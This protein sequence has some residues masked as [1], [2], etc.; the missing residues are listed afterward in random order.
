MLERGRFK[1]RGVYFAHPFDN[2]YADAVGGVSVIGA[3]SDWANKNEGVLALAAVIFPLLMILVSFVLSFFQNNHLRE[4]LLDLRSRD[5]LITRYSLPGQD[6]YFNGL[7]RVLRLAEWIY[8]PKA[9]SWR[10]YGSCL[11]IAVIYPLLAV[12]LGWVLF[13]I[14]NPAGIEM[15]FD[16]ENGRERALRFAVFTLGMAVATFVFR[17]IDN[18]SDYLNAQ[19]PKGLDFSKVWPG[20]L[21][22]AA[23]GLGPP[24]IFG[25]AVAFAFAFAAAVAGAFAFAG[26]GAFAF[27]VAFAGTFAVAFAFAS[28]SA[29]AVAFAGA[30]AFG[31]AEAALILLLYVFLPILNAAADMISLWIT[32]GFL[33]N[34]LTHRPH[35]GWVLAQ[36]LVDL[37]LAA[38]C[39]AALIAL[40]IGGLTIWAEISPASV[41][42]DWRAYWADVHADPRAGVAL[43]IMALT[44]LV[45]TIIHVFS[46]LAALF[47]QK[48]WMLQPVVAELSEQPATEA[49]S[50]A[51]VGR[52]ERKIR[53]A[54]IL[55][56]LAACM[57]VAVLFIPPIWVVYA[58]IT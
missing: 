40:I 21:S 38:L 35:F 31:G 13:N 19:I 39:L 16:T 12:M 58:L 23:Q 4:E 27:A 3:I 20:F 33:R 44:T 29:F 6:A 22:K 46:G 47:T 15:F 34:V 56:N 26:A 24:V 50:A 55:G 1:A 48:A 25:V 28:A 49:F 41:P 2:L 51:S 52:L 5:E 57:A 37:A 18:M 14:W 53:R 32:R 30:F 54:S 7:A 10:A 36:L 43:Y 45:P 17:N 11:T 8:G 42:L 9:L